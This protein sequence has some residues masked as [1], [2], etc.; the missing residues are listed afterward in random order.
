[1]ENNEIEL[2]ILIEVQPGKADYQID[3]FK[4]LQPIVLNEKGC[5]EYRLCKISG[6]NN[7]FVLTERWASAEDLLA[8]D[9]TP[10]MQEADLITPSF[11]A[12]PA[13]VLQLNNL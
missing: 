7:Q 10:H 12:K 11:R 5:I 13:T 6:N 3:L 9:K 8:H 4:K 2:I 1:M